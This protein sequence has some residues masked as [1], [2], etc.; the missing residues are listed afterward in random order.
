MSHLSAFQLLNIGVHFTLALVWAIVAQNAWRFVRLRRPQSRFFR[1]LPVVGG[2][3]SGTYLIF[4]LTTLI[5]PPLQIHPTDAVVILWALNDGAVFAVVALARHMARFFPMPEERPPK[6]GWLIVNYGAGALMI[7]L[8]LAYVGLVAVPFVKPH[9]AGYAVLRVL[10]QLVMLGLIV[11]QLVRVA[12]P[13]VWVPGGAA[14]VARRADVVVLGGALVSLSGWLLIVAT[15]RSPTEQTMWD[16]SVWSVVL[17][18]ITGIG[19]AIPL[20]VRV[21]G[22]V[23]RGVLLTAMMLA[24]T[25][26]VYLGMQALGVTLAH[27][28]MRALLDFGTVLALVCLFMPGQAWLRGAIDH[29]VFRR[30][31]RRQEELRAFLHA[32]SPELGAGECCRRALAEV[33][34]VMQLRGAAILLRDGETVIDGEIRSAALER[35]WRNVSADA[36]PAGALVGYELRELADPLKQALVETDVVGVIPIATPRRRRGILLISTGLLGA[37]FS[38]EDERTLMAFADQLGLVLDGTELLAR[39]VAV[40]RSLAHTEKL[41]AIGE[42]AARIAHEI[43]NP[44]TAARSLA[45]QLCRDPVS[46]LNAEHAELIL[47]ELER[48][49]RQIVALLRF[50][51]REEFRLESTDIGELVRSLIQE[52][53]PR[54]EAA[55]IS[56][57]VQAD[58][59]VAA[60]ADREKI[61]QVLINLIEN[62]IDA[63]SETNGDRRLSLALTQTNGTAILRMCDNG[64]G[65]PADVLPRLFE[66]FFSLKPKGTGLGLAIAKRTVDAH[67]GS[68]TAASLSAGLT[69]TIHLPLAS[70]G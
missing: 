18:A 41:A 8:T 68:I 70:R 49:E 47:S 58:D 63:L 51:R 10:Y 43:R 11:W 15:R 29:L 31:R 61:R 17:D 38:D 12:R 59:D 46:P 19:F 57:D 33:R 24:A 62:A 69:F 2:A 66:P 50:A 36:F 16:P 3:V 5:P 42:L 30:S 25:T 48:V 1:M 20:A 13:G 44:V 32:L 53:A 55:A 52:F 67:G 40:E 64:P 45:Q 27:P 35:F 34:R 37:T 6:P 21:L 54:L 4:T 56:V 26:A 9:F 60:H 39:A 23:V 65:V 22:E 28:E 14:W 7:V